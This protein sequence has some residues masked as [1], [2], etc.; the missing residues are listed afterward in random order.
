MTPAAAHVPLRLVVFDLDG[1]LVDSWKD[2]ADSAN[3]LVREYGG[4]PLAD[5]AVASM[6]GDGAA[7]LVERVCEAAGL[8]APPPEALARFLAI[9]DTRLLDHTTAY[10]G[11]RE[12][13]QRLSARV[14]LAVLTNKPGGATARVL[15]GLDLASYFTWVVAGDGPFGRKPDPEGLLH[16]VREAGATVEHTLLVGDSANDLE[17]AR[18]AG[19]NICLARYGFG[20][21]L[22]DRELR[23]DEL[24]ADTPRRIAEIVESRRT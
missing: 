7:V 4:Q 21:R 5:A 13:L 22:A 12:V 2:L 24:L 6:I 8:G 19:T 11:V 15:E 14:R 23:G 18:Q 10:P 17:T 9:Y 16:L 20:Y 1:T 3:D